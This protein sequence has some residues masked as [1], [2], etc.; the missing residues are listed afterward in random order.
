L[1]GD[2]IKIEHSMPDKPEVVLLADILRIDQDAVAGKLLRVW[3]WSDQQSVSGDDLTGTESFIDRLTNCPGFAAGLLKVGWLNSRNGRY[4]VPNFDRH[5]GQTAKSRVLSRDRMKRSR[6]DA[7]VTE[8][9]QKL[10]RDR[11]EIEKSKEEKKEASA[12]FVPPTVEQV[13]EYCQSRGNSV[14][15]EYF[16]AHYNANGWVQ[17]KSARKLKSWKDA[18]ITWEKNGVNNSHSGNGKPPPKPVQME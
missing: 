1:A 5:N 10:V 14:D 7:N 3:I 17:G 8:M 15:P 4:S 12:R 2:W 18:V 13:R 11:E 6:Y 9:Q 16:V